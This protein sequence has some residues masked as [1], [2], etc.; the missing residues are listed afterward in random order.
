MQHKLTVRGTDITIFSQSDADFVSLTDMAKGF[1]Q[2][3]DD[4]KNTDYFILNWLRLGST[5]EFLGAWEQLHNPDFN[6]VGFD[7]IKLQ[8]TKNT[9]RL[10]AKKWVEET[11]AIGIQAKAGR[12]GGTYAHRDIAH[13]FCYWLSP[14]FQIY[15]IKEFQRLKA[16][17]RETIGWDIRRLISK[18]NFH[19]HA[20]SVR[21]NLVPIVERGTRNEGFFFASEGDLLNMAVFGLTAAQWK[22]G[23]P[24]AKG[25]QRDHAS[26]EQLI[27]LANLEAINAEFIREGL[28]Q[29]ERLVR[30]NEIAMYQMR[31]L[32]KIPSIKQL[33]SSN[34]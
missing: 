21:H 23:N 7:R 22:F 16:E 20:D 27:I 26:H 24:E 12:Y 1:I 25:N 33:P 19:I 6:P 32:S 10:S 28:S 29:D 31:I 13:Q 34:L 5:V 11:A 15:F 8:L 14:T 18:V 17:R 4:K 30:L 9:F 3:E 2:V